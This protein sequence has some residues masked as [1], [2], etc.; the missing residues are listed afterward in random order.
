[1]PLAQ[2]SSRETVSRNIKHEMG[3]GK[4]QDQAVAIALKQ[5]G[6]S[7]YQEQ[8]QRGQF[9]LAARK[10]REQMFPHLVQKRRR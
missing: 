6:L 10:L 5:A 2:G 7:K 8:R 9:A 3:K 1:M 4:P